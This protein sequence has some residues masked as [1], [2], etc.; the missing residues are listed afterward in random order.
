MQLFI[1]QKLRA[2]QMV[3]LFWNQLLLIYVCLLY[4]NVSIMH[5][6]NPNIYICSFRRYRQEAIA[7]LISI[8]SFGRHCYPRD[9]EFNPGCQLKSWTC[10]RATVEPLSKAFNPQL[11][12]PILVLDSITLWIKVPAKWIHVNKPYSGS[13]AMSTIY[14]DNHSVP[15]LFP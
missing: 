14:T 2:I 8:Y 5:F 15:Q 12:S 3:Q 10:Q 4:S 9:A 6:L 11:L 7:R 13:P 1:I